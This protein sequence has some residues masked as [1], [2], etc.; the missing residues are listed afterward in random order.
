MSNAIKYAGSEKIPEIF[1]KTEKVKDYILLTVKDNGIGIE[2]DKQESIFSRY[3]RIKEDVE[4]SGVG[5][6]LVKRMVEDSG[7]KIEVESSLG[8]GSIFKIFIK[9]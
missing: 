4:G 3:T 8:E 9:E 7:G 1:I 6:F 5:L 2:A